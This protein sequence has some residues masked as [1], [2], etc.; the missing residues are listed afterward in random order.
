MDN[1]KSLFTGLGGKLLLLVL[2][3][4]LLMGIIALVSNSGMQSSQ[5][6]ASA[7]LMQ[8]Q[9]SLN[10]AAAE[11]A[12]I[13][14]LV[15][16]SLT[17]VNKMISGHQTSMLLQNAGAASQTAQAV[18]NSNDALETLEDAAKALSE[19]LQT[20]G[21]ISLTVAEATTASDNP[22]LLSQDARLNFFNA[23]RLSTN[24]LQAFHLLEESNG[25]TLTFIEAQNFDAARNNF[26]FEEVSRINTFN[27]LAS[28]LQAALDTLG[29]DLQ[30]YAA[31]KQTA[32]LED[33]AATSSEVATT[34]NLVLV[35]ALVIVAIAT[36]LFS[37]RLLVKPL[38]DQVSAMT[39]LSGGDMDVSIPEPRGDEL[40]DISR[41]LHTFRDNLI[42]R[43]RLREEQQKAEELE[44][45]RQ[46]EQEEL[47][48]AR[49]EEE[50]AAER[51]KAEQEAEKASR[52]DAIIQTFREHIEEAVQNLSQSSDNM[53]GA[54][55][56]MVGIVEDTDQKVNG[57][58]QASG[59]MQEN[60]TTIASALE[61]YST[62]ISEVNQQVQSANGI[63]ANA[64]TASDSGSQAIQQ[65]ASSSQEIENVVKLISDIAEQTN[66]LALNA[67][68][69][70]ARAGEAG[71]GFAVVASE[72]KS[73]ANQTASATEEITNQIKGMQSVTEKAVSSIETIGHTVGELNHVM[74]S[75]SS[76][77]EEQQATTSEINRS[78]QYASDSTQQVN[79]DIAVVAESAKRTG[80]ASSTV[81]EA[82]QK[83]DMLSGN[84]KTEVDSFIGDVRAL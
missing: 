82:S 11:V 59:A 43:E 58:Q 48:R 14:S 57:V 12:E 46:R 72:V 23:L 15:R 1:I 51:A 45:E 35:A 81:L 10:E 20:L 73:L 13:N 7:T 50:R 37:Q 26:R 55:S 78:V 40:G 66:L 75:I 28:N 4:M 68:I 32:L 24:T 17:L 62:S 39:A 9:Q 34:A 31:A 38:K 80:Q 42:E 44:R 33:Q 60:V 54:A 29:T 47:D 63:S 67:T 21:L 41:A 77:V 52:L 65:L 71:K 61:Q 84:I 19:K 18:G 8:N 25:R 56:E 2:V 3:P 74:I 36:N 27:K 76:A 64:V 30:R 49:Q 22:D 83:V 53:S 16:T 5:Q 79:N 69:E 6:E 70:A